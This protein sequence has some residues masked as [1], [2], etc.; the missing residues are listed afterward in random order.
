MGFSWESFYADGDWE[1]GAYIGG[2]DM[3]DHLDAFVDFVGGVGSVLSVGCGPATAEFEVARRRPDVAVHCVDP[4]ASVVEA[5]RKKAARD[6]VENVTFAVAGLPD[7]D[8]DGGEGSDTRTYDVVYCMAVL[9][10]VPDSGPALQSLWDVVAPGG[11]LA[12]TYPN[13]RMQSWARSIEDPERRAAFSLVADGENLLS[14]DRI[15]AVL[16]TYPRNYW[17]AVDADPDAEYVTRTGSPAVY[18]R[19]PR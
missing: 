7:L 18:L 8:L 5:N 9:Y 1:R 16:G 17:R 14:Y 12:F 4:A 10:F 19:K 6:G 2:D 11:A 15:Q 13:R 3:A